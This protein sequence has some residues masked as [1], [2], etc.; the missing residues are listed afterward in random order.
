MKAITKIS[1]FGK[2]KDLLLRRYAR[3]YA[4]SS[5][6]FALTRKPNGWY[7]LIKCCTTEMQENKISSLL[8]NSSSEIMNEA[9]YIH[10]MLHARVA[11]SSKRR[12]YWTAIHKS[13]AI[14]LN[15]PILLQEKTH[16]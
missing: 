15:K 8:H 3:D 16:G 12:N 14:A 9:V 11:K 13:R 6:G 2:D 7:M 4:H 1:L 10:S 5:I